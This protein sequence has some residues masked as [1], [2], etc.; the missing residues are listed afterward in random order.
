MSIHAASNG[1]TDKAAAARGGESVIPSKAKATRGKAQLG[2][3]LQMEAIS[4]AAANVTHEMETDDKELSEEDVTEI[5]EAEET[6]YES[7]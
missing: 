1:F 4:S 2:A 7:G 6:E 3:S 5:A